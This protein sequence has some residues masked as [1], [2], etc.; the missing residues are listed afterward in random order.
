MPCDAI[1]KSARGKGVE[2]KKKSLIYLREASRHALSSTPCLRHT[3]VTHT[4]ETHTHTHNGH[5]CRTRRYTCA[6]TRCIHTCNV[7]VTPRGRRLK[8]PHTRPCKS[9]PAVLPRDVPP[10]A[11]ATRQISRERSRVLHACSEYSRARVPPNGRSYVDEGMREPFSFP[12]SLSIYLCTLLFAFCV[13]FF[14]A[15]SPSSSFSLPL[16]PFLYLSL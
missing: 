4:C 1:K 6:L 2:R 8:Y 10:R 16:S 14:T 11:P 9:V 7:R 5:N 12:L 13:D 3:Y 15:F